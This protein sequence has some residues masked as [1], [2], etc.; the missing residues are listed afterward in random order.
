MYC[1]PLAKSKTLGL[2]PFLCAL[3][4]IASGNAVAGTCPTEILT[5]NLQGGEIFVSS[6]KNSLREVSHNMRLTLERDGRININFVIRSD[7]LSIYRAVAFLRKTNGVGEVSLDENVTISNNLRNRG[8]ATT[9]RSTYYDYHRRNNTNRLI[10]T[11]FHVLYDYFRG[12]SF[13]NIQDPSSFL[14]FFDDNAANYWGRIQRY[15]GMNAEI[16]CANVVL[17]TPGPAPRHV[18]DVTFRIISLSEI[19]AIPSWHD[20]QVSFGEPNDN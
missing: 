17:F 16:M 15:R 8:E 14:N 13:S 7:D 5:K 4:T 18:N 19:E 2:L 9:N 12:N 11:R 20:F 6:P 10:T 3:L 1:P